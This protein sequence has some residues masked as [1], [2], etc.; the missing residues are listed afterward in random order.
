MS[1]FVSTEEFL[2][3]KKRYFPNSR[4]VFTNGCFDILHPGHINYLC[5]AKS[6]GDILVIGL[7]S[8]YSVQQLKGDKRPIN[9]ERD[10]AFVLSS[11]QCVDFII[12]FHE[13]TP[14]QTISAILPDVLVKGGD[15]PREQIVGR[16]IVERKAEGK[17]YSLPLLEGYSTSGLIC[18]IISLE[19]KADPEKEKS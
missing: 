18:R 7:N 4:V 19:N 1:K 15:W 9:I 14:L 17:V 13:E 2:E 5:R 16:E 8:D 11:L 3:K 10:R 6:L 12:V